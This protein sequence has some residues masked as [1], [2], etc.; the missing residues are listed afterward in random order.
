MNIEVRRAKKEDFPFIIE[1]S[2]QVI[3]YGI[4]RIRDTDIETVK[5]HMARAYQNISKTYDSQNK[6]IILIAVDVEKNEQVG[7]LTL[8]MDEVEGATGERQSFIHDLAVRKKYWGKYVVNKLMYQAE[9]ETLARGLHI[10]TGSISVNNM[11]AFGTATK[12]L[13]YE[14]ERYQIIKKI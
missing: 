11:R 12:A 8:I 6:F 9:V 13:G 10:I 14:L 5:S 7:F 2:G 1:L 3:Q 4:P